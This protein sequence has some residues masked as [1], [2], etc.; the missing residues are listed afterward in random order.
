MTSDILYK[1]ECGDLFVWHTDFLLHA[2]NYCRLTAKTKAEK[3]VD[4][5]WE[6]NEY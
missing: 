3:A 2:A 1:C 5:A 4:D 6:K